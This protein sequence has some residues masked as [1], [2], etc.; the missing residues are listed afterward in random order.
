MK[1]FIFLSFIILNTFA[2]NNRP[3]LLF[4]IVDDLNDLPIGSPLGNVIKTPHIDRLDKRGVSF[5]N[6][7]TNDPICAPS[8]ASMLY[9]L[10]PQTSGMFWFEKIKDRK[11]LRESIDFPN[12]LKNNNYKLFGTGKIYHGGMPKK[13][14]D[15]YGIRTNFGPH[16]INGDAYMGH[17]SDQD[18]LFKKFPELGYKWEQTFGPL[19]Q[20][21]DWSHLANG[22]KGWFLGKTPWSMNDGHNRDLLP[23][24]ISADYCKKIL[25]QKHDKNFALFAG[26][27]RTHTPLYAPQEYFDRFPLDSIVVPNNL[28]ISDFAPSIAN[29]SRYGFQRY[30]FLMQEKD[31]LKKWIQAYLAC[32]SFVDDQ[33][34]SIL[35]ALE[36]SDYANNTMIIFTSDHGFHMG[37]KQFLYKQSLWDGATRVPFIISAPGMTTDQECSKPVSHIDIY[38]TIIDILKLKKEPNHGKSNTPLDGH[39]LKTLLQDPKGEWKGPKVAITALPGKDHSMNRV[40]EGAM[41]PHFSV[42]SEDFRYTLS[43]AGEEELFHYPKDPLETKNLADKAEYKD[44]KSTL[45]KELLQLRDGNAW[46]A[47]PNSLNAKD[48]ELEVTSKQSQF[49]IHISPKLAIANGLEGSPNTWRIRLQGKRLEIWLNNKLLK[50]ELVKHD[51]EYEIQAESNVLQGR[52]RLL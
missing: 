27:V 52:F 40:F 12:H 18:Y 44:I 4:I 5:T 43:S 7:H 42:R 33:V 36:E 13:T 15:S 16:P 41:R 31:L 50:D 22:K 26:L 11:V 29:K 19:E 30:E 8:R 3:N 39:S 17:H 9:G 45:K 32:V 14:F 37:D 23:D 34:G 24:E 1:I 46:Q 2:A 51:S 6:A 10:Y 49:P 35:D 25:N 38:P 48:F 28:N 21:P 20:A 47:F